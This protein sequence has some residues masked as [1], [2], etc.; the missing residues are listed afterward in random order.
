MILTDVE[1]V[2]LNYGDV[3]EVGIGRMTVAEAEKYLK[4][5]QFGEGSMKPKTGA[6]INFVKAGG[7]KKR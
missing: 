5:D 1:Q 7:K 4:G 3:G 2:I 6:G